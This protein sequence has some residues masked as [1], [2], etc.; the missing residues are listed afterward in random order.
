MA[1]QD[2]GVIL[3]VN[4]IGMFIVNAVIKRH[5]IMILAWVG[6]LHLRLLRGILTAR[7]LSTVTVVVINELFAEQD[8]KYNEVQLRLVSGQLILSALP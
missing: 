5:R 3:D 2:T 7:N 6:L 4:K 8:W 1:I